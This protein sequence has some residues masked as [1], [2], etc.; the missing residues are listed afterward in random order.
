MNII[1][2][3]TQEQISAWIN[4]WQQYRTENAAEMREMPSDIPPEFFV[5]YLCVS[6]Y[7]FID[8]DD[9]AMHALDEFIAGLSREQMERLDGYLIAFHDYM[10]IMGVRND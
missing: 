2:P 3:P 7:G 9:N 6:A 1:E 5:F 10:L 4:S 8:G